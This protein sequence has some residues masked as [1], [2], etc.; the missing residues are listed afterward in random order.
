M[1]PG[2]FLPSIAAL[3]IAAALCAAQNQ[4]EEDWATPRAAQHESPIP[5][6]QRVDINHASLEKLMKIPGIT[7]IWA[8]RIVRFRPYRTKNALVDEGILPANVYKRV[9]DSIIAHRDPQ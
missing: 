9:R 5:D 6:W 4:K 1:S 3:A 2:K 8:E 7:Q